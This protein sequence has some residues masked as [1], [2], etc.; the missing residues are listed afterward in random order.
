MPV[1]VVR[2]CLFS[3]LYRLIKILLLLTL[4]LHPRA[5]YASIRCTDSHHAHVAELVDALVSGSSG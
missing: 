1:T 5:R 3:P 4:V 2:S